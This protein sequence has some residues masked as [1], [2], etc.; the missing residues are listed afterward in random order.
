MRR[1]LA[2]FEKL[3]LTKAGKPE[4]D[5]RQPIEDAASRYNVYVA[6]CGSIVLLST[7]LSAAPCL[8]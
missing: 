7:I 6:R 4:R 1:G 3:S 2:H 8:S 5:S